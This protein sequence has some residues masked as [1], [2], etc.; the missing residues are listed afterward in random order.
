MDTV[1]ASTGSRSKDIEGQDAHESHEAV[2]E[3]GQ[4]VIVPGRWPQRRI[5]VA[6][7]S[8]EHTREDEAGRWVYAPM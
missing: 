3:G 4:I 7:R 2:L 5:I 8:F 6:G 1:H